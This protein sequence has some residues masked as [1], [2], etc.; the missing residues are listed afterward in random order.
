M[1]P[2]EER[3]RMC[4]LIQEMDKNKEIAKSMGL[5]DAS[6]NRDIEVRKG[7]TSKRIKENRVK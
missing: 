2:I 5:R 3:I 1:N 6:Y 7:N 4:L